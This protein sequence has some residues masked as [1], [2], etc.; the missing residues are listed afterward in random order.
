L[1]ETGTVKPCVRCG[2]EKPLEAFAR[3]GKARDGRKSVCKQCNAGKSKA[4]REIEKK[5]VERTRYL[6]TRTG[7]RLCLGLKCTAKFG[8]AT[9]LASLNRRYLCS[10]C[11]VATER[12]RLRGLFKQ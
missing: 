3:H 9:I 2:V 4:E 11:Y 8:R 5:D 6:D 12:E 1:S 10:L 7:K